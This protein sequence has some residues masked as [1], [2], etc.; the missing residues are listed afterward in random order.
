LLRSIAGV[1]QDRA[2][3]LSDEYHIPEMKPN[4]AQSA[5]ICISPA[6]TKLE[7]TA[8]EILGISMVHLAMS[9]AAP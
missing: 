4:A 9:K 7:V 2:S 6:G 8:K 5:W 1:R 3:K